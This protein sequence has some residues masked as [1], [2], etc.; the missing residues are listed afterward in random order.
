MC[1]AT[2]KPGISCGRDLFFYILNLVC[3]G[4][5]GEF[6]VLK[7]SI[8]AVSAAFCLALFNRHPSS[9]VLGYFSPLSL[10]SFNSA[11]EKSEI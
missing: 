7:V 5:K 4:K 9:L 6:N 3:T 10:R 11:R 2:F 8:I 1:N